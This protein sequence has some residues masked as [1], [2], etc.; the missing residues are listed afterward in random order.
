RASRQRLDED[1]VEQARLLLKEAMVPFYLTRFSAAVR[2]LKRGLRVLERVESPA[3]AGQR[4][5][6][7]VW[8]ATTRQRQRRPEDAIA[9][10][11]RAGAD[12]ERGEDARHALGHAYVIL[13]W[14]YEVSGRA[15]EA[16]YLPLALAIFEELGDL[17]WISIA[18][19]NMG[20]RAYEE[21]RWND[22][23]E[24]ARRAL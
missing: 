1:P 15:D 2:W 5:R 4:A 8:L 21:G 13:D 22:S 12:A 24:L 19:N 16:T 17:E 3:A 23:L 18:L 14:A 9:W 11:R 6:L 7:A 10:C 20:G